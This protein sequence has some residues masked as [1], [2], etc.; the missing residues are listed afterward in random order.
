MGFWIWT[1]NFVFFVLN[2]LIKGD[3]EKLSGQ[4]L[5]LICD[6]SLTCWGLNSNLRNFDGS[7]TF[8]FVLCGES[9]LLVSWCVGERCGMTSSDEDHGRSRRPGAEDWG[10]LS[11]GRV[12]GDW[13]IGRSRDTVCG[14]CCARG[15]EMHMFLGGAS[16]PRSI[17]C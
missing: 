16:K 8:T 12:L 2:G 14:L 4:Y 7:T 13:T 9:H 17:V 6:E 1:S 15:G 10:W 3:I 11:I 5:G